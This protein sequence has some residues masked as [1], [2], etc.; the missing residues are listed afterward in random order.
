VIPTLTAP[1]PAP[2]RRHAVATMPGPAAPRNDDWT[3][4]D[5]ATGT[6]VVA[7]GVGSARHGGW[8]ARFVV[9]RLPALLASTGDPSDPVLLAAFVRTLSGDLRAKACHRLGGIGT[10]VVAAVVQGGTATIAHVG[11][12]RAYLSRA[13]RLDRLTTDHALGESLVATGILDAKAA[14]EL[15]GRTRLTQHIGMADRVEPAVRA[16][17]LLPS[18]RLLLCSDGLTAVLDDATIAAVLASMPVPGTPGAASR[19]CDALL[20]AAMARGL[21]DDTTVLVIG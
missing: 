1:T 16:V 20:G 10:T 11:D 15:P 12:S 13:G 7:D 14:A 19:C 21:V 3:S 5:D 4:A 9:E 17:A 6:Y 8:S 18:D 2:T